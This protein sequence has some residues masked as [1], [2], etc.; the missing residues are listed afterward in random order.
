MRLT[1]LLVC[2]VANLPA[3]VRVTGAVQDITGAPVAGAEVSMELQPPVEGVKRAR[4]TADERGLFVFEGVTNGFYKVRAK[5]TGLTAD[6]VKLTV[7]D[8]APLPITMLMQA[9]QQA[10]SVT[11][12]ASRKAEESLVTLD[13]NSDQLNFEENLL[14][15]LPAPGQ[16]ILGV[17]AGFASP[18]AQGAEGLDIAVDGMEAGGADLPPGSIRRVRVNR[19]PYTVTNR[20]PGRARVDVYTE[21]GSFRRTKASFGIYARNSALDSRNAFARTKPDYT[22]YLFD[23]NF[24]GNFNGGRIA[25]FIS[26]DRLTDNG[27]ALVNAVTLAGPLVDNVPTP[28]RRT[29]VLA[30]LD[31]KAGSRHTLLGTYSMRDRAEEIRGTG[32]LRL[33]EQGYS[34]SERGHRFQFSDQAL[35]SESMLNDFRAAYDFEDTAAG[36]AVESAALVVHGAFVSGPPQRYTTGRQNVLRIRDSANYYAGM[37]ALKFGGDI[38]LGWYRALD[39]TN[40]GGTYDFAGLDAFAN[41]APFRYRVNTGDPRVSFRQDEAYGYIQDEMTLSPTVQ[42]MAGARYGWQS[43]VKDPFGV[44]PRVALAWAAWQGKTVVRIGA[45]VFYERVSSELARL[46][47]LYDGSRLQEYVVANPSYPLPPPVVSG[48]LPPSIVTAAPDL[49]LPY[50]AQASATVEQQVSRSAH[51]SLEYQRLRGLHLLRA[52]N[53][54]APLPG[55]N[56]FSGVQRLAPGLLNVNQTESSA[57]M[58]SESWTATWRGNLFARF[59]GMAQYSLSR[60]FDNTN[61]SFELPANSFDYRAEWG[62]ANYDQRHRVSFAGAYEMDHGFRAGAFVTAASGLPYNITTG[63]DDNNDTVNNDRPTGVTR[64]TG[65]GPNRFTIDLRVTRSFRVPRLLDRGQQ[66]SSRNIDLN[67]DFFNLL[68]RVNPVEY[69]GVRTSPFFGRANAAHSPRTIQLSLRWRL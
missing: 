16:D 36:G 1:V 46:S 8:A 63:R 10:T 7:Q 4:T 14:E 62:R 52:R 40:F 61:G 3:Q 9:A 55:S 32:G 54:N 30:R 18:A 23:G 27:N 64:N 13:R 67:I 12:N 47:L 19:N 68:N 53:V 57:S 17:V 29:H 5:A 66:H 34:S 37:H 26:A 69:I 58:R 60:S 2:A 31:T 43:N 42:F 6:S 20:R 22:R 11:V 49:R 45:G 35:V 51:V 59:S 65:L 44:A 48:S 41:G 56:P 15:G 50:V 33:A 25:Y 38:R 28:E 24:G 39:R 21:E